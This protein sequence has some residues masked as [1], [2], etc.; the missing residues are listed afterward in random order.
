MSCYTLLLRLHAAIEL[1]CL[2]QPLPCFRAVRLALKHDVLHAEFPIAAHCG[3]DLLRCTCQGLVEEFRF[4]CLE[5]GE[6]EPDERC[7][8]ESGRV[9]PALAPSRFEVVASVGEVFWFA[10]SPGSSQ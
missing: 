4:F 9:P 3:C 6:P 2:G 8:A 7:Y 10:H 1:E 5:V